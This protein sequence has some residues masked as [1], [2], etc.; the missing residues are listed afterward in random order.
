MTKRTLIYIA[1]ALLCFASVSCKKDTTLQ[2][3]NLTMGNITEGEFV[4]D[5]GNIFNITEKAE[6]I[7]KD[8]LDMKRAYILCDVLN[9]T[10]GGRDN[11]YDV[12]LNAF[13]EVK[14]K[15]IIALG[16]EVT[17]ESLVEDPIQVDQAW[18]SGGYLNL[19]IIFAMKE[20]SQTPHLVN[21]VQQ[22][23]QEGYVFKLTHN[24]YGENMDEKSVW[25]AGY[26]SFPVN[27]II[28]ENSAKVKLEW[29][30][31]KS[32]GTSLS[33][34]TEVKS[35]EGT[36]TKGGFEHGPMSIKAMNRG[37]VK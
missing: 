27:A 34:E 11:E 13:A 30:W 26:I 4:S 15:D 36:Y 17:E 9:K 29:T 1:S 18:F 8:I 23:S 22:E 33:Q 5:Q 16:A 12:R 2:Y 10:E 25:G 21:L 24:A 14:V 19:Y 32:T 7:K 28:S 35:I 20:G 31:Y 37:M 6:S 3:S